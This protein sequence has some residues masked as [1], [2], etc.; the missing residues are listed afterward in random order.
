MDPLFSTQ[1]WQTQYWVKFSLLS[2]YVFSAA[3]K[4]LSPTLLISFGIA[5]AGINMQQWMNPHQGTTKNGASSGGLMIQFGSNKLLLSCPT[6]FVP[7]TCAPAAH[8]DLGMSPCTQD[9]NTGIPM[10][11]LQH[12]V[13]NLVLKLH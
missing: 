12:T 4:K 5:Q 13:L 11:F 2:S 10:R 6:Y 7:K 9:N 8:R 1:P 3:D